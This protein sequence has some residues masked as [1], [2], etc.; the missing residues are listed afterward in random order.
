MQ[1]KSHSQQRALL[2]KL[3][4]KNK[5]PHAI[6]L[7][8]PSGI[9]KRQAAHELVAILVCED[10]GAV[11]R[12]QECGKCKSCSLFKSGN[13]PDYREIEC[14]DRQAANAENIRELLY[15]LN[16]NAFLAGKRIVLFDN[17][18]SMSLQSAN[19][20]LKS[21]E[22]PR[23]DT[24]FILVTSNPYRLPATLV[25]RCQLIHFNVLS[26]AEIKEVIAASAEMQSALGNEISVAELS[27]LCNGSFED[28]HLIIENAELWREMKEGLMNAAKGDPAQALV[29]A[30]QLSKDK[31]TLRAKLRVL[32]GLARQS[33]RSALSDRLLGEKWGVF[34]THLTLAER[35][36]FERNLSAAY[37]LNYILITL[38]EG[39]ESFTAL[40][41]SVTLLAVS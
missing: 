16:L 34:L 14:R 29:L 3:S 11:A 27:E 36:I 22:E 8:G 33:L 4:V 26:P 40:D 17:A 20:L 37:V 7:A 28:L 9:G 12:Y 24:H 6:L 35:L 19:I 18:E 1:L 41:E 21:L 5:L 38:T 2:K 39:A 32:Q 25:S 31:E 15:S 23:K 30:E 13:L 10:K